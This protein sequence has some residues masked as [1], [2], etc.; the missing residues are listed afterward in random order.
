MKVAPSPRTF[1]HLLEH[2]CYRSAHYPGGSIVRVLHWLVFLAMPLALAG[3]G[4]GALATS[5]GAAAMS[6]TTTAAPTA[7]PPA[8]VVSP[9]TP[10]PVISALTAKPAKVPAAGG[11]VSVSAAVANATTCKVASSPAPLFGAGAVPCDSG[12]MTDSLLL[13]ANP[14]PTSVRYNIKVTA[15]GP[16][17]AASMSVKVK[18]LG[19]GGGSEG[20]HSMVSDGDGYCALFDSGTVQCWGLGEFGELGNGQFYNPSGPGGSAS[21]VQVQG[22]GGNGALSNVASLTSDGNGYGYCALLDSGGVDCWG[23]GEFGELGNGQ[24]YTAVPN[25]SATTVRVADTDGT[26]TLSGVTSLASGGEGYCAVLTSGGVDCWGY[27]PDGELGNGQYYSASPNGSA[28]P[29]Q[30]IDTDGGG[31]LAGVADLT[32][33][34]NGYCAVLTSGALDCWGAGANGQLGNG[35]FYQGSP[36]GSATPVAVLDTD[37]TGALS[38]VSSVTGDATGA[39]CAVLTSGGVA[40]WGFGQNG[41]LGN[42]PPSSSG[43]NSAVPVSVVDTDGGGT[44]A[45]VT[46]LTGDAD[47]YCA[48]TAGEVA[49]WGNGT[50]G[51]LGNGQFSDSATPVHVAGVSGTG[52]LSGVATTTGDGSGVCALLRT[53]RVNCWGAG[54]QGD[55]GDGKFPNGSALPV[56]VKG[57]GGK[58]ALSGVAGLT[59]D[60]DGYC[61]MLAAG[62]VNCWGAGATGDLGNGQ[63]YAQ[64]PFGSA[65]PV[66][67]AWPD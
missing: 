56:Q 9:L 60:Q 31:L 28:L 18:V 37:G 51:Q 61:V 7:N 23:F 32:G 65:V 19:V 40:C 5:S 16:G 44:L 33:D 22:V 38:G 20:V 15:K 21:P 49:C 48:L 6:A 36:D 50:L 39:Y 1:Q 67:V 62:G 10:A 47:G 42:G 45:G 64:N 8:P 4:T 25:G 58:T 24:F 53:G 29:V 41:E 35:R 46:S 52:K 59:G 3:V 30:V 2:H 27:G 54:G 14:L 17:G 26:G 55:L 43:A 63:F 34:G 13:A 11:P 12:T 66:Q 57:L